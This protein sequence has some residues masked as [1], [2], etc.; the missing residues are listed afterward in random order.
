MTYHT[1][2]KLLILVKTRKKNMLKFVCRGGCSNSDQKRHAFRSII[3]VGSRWRVAKKLGRHAVCSS[4]ESSRASFW[5]WWKEGTFCAAFFQYLMK[6][7]G[8]VGGGGGEGVLKSGS[9]LVSPRVDVRS[10]RLQW[11]YEPSPSSCPPSKTR[12]S[13]QTFGQ[14]FFELFTSTSKR[15]K[16]CLMIHD[17][18]LRRSALSASC[19]GIKIL[20]VSVQMF[21]FFFWLSDSCFGRKKWSK[22]FNVWPCLRC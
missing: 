6:K 3:W 4:M 21:Y 14:D 16:D 20:Q 11:R 13:T 17:R 8:R 15:N 7:I 5:V 12:S 9:P 18:S 22:A 10:A 2:C 1:A 19:P